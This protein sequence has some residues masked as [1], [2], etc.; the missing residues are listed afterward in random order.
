MRHARRPLAEFLACEEV[1]WQLD[2]YYVR[3]MLWPHRKVPDNGFIDRQHDRT[4]VRQ[5]AAR[6]KRLDFADVMENPRFLS[7]LE[8]W[9]GRHYPRFNETTPVPAEFKSA[10][11]DE[12]TPLALG[13]L[14]ARDAVGPRAMDDA[15]A[16]APPDTDVEGLR[17]RALI[18]NVARHPWLMIA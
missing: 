11:H 1:A 10:L 2:N 18:G 16:A 17:E 8:K 15:G 13:L 14:E 7:N 6:L 4:L 12:L 3:A 5:A 9:I